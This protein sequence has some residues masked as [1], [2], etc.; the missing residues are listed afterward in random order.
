MSF[1]LIL[2]KIDHIIYTVSSALDFNS[3]TLGNSSVPSMGGRKNMNLGNM[4]NLYSA[5]ITTNFREQIKIPSQTT[6]L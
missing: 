1:I 2:C 3:H 4:K 5:N 6:N